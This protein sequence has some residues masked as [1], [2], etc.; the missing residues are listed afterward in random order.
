MVS[1]YSATQSS[2]TSAGNG[3]MIAL[4]AASR[5]LVNKFYVSGLAGGGMDGGKPGP[6]P[7][8]GPACFAYIHSLDGNKI[9]AFC[10][11]K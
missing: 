10:E 4:V 1:M 6:R 11:R 8:D 5:A 3:N 7:A 9:C 2:A